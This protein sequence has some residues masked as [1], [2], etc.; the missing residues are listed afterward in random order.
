MHAPDSSF[1]DSGVK[2]EGGYYIN[3]QIFRKSEVR[4]AHISQAPVSD[5]IIL[6]QFS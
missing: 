5:V 4:A 1:K 3:R 6:L 2:R